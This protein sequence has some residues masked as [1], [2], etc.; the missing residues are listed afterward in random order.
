M[1]MPVR[2]SEALILRSFPLGEADRLV[3]FLS[4]TEGRMRGVASGARRPKSRFGSTLELFSYIRIWFYERE[5]RELV[6]INQ[7]E[8][9]ESFLEAQRDYSVTLAFGLMS[10]VTEAVLGEHEVA[11][12]NFRLLLVIARALKAGV[13]LPLALAYFAFWIVRLGGWMP[14]LDRCSRCGAALTARAS[15]AKSGLFCPNCALPGQRAI[16]QEALQF[17]RK[18]S[19]EKLEQL[20]KA[21]LP[22]AALE[23]LKD[24]MLNLIE[25]HIEKKLQTRKMLAEA[26]EPLT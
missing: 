1:P 21:D 8:L 10:E 3:S 14:P 23:E 12:P 11:E 6:R 2:E 19:T 15:M 4:R 24:H 26:L 7:C 25:Q 22:V 13:K 20:M 5:T 17:A 18:M 16:S 9:I